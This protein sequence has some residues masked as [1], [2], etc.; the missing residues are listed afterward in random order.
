MSSGT[1][2]DAAFKNRV[3]LECYDVLESR[4]FTRF[5][6]HDVDWP[7]HD[8]FYC[9][10]GLNSALYP[11]RVEL[12]P[13]VGVHVVPIHKMICELDNG[14]Y[15]RNYDRGVATFAI[16]IGELDSVGEERAFVF[17]SQQSDSFISSE[18]NRLA[19]LYATEGFQYAK[20]IAS[21]E[22]LA[23]LLEENVS[24]L[25]GNPERFAACLYMMG[26][27]VEAREFL[28]TFP[29]QYKEFI[30]GFSIP[31]LEKVETEI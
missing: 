7:I 6:K 16:N 11:D 3:L 21:Y 14:E 22:S 20:S 15:A 24:T 23:P 17:S 31:F 25:G 10:V 29:E 5:R 1:V 8:G 9:W 2:C 26:K 28:N 27:K 13:N 18:C 12:V 4:G 30:K 19:S